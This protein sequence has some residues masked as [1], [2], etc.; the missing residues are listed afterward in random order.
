MKKLFFIAFLLCSMAGISQTFDV[1]DIINGDTL[2]TS[3]NHPDSL[4]KSASGVWTFY[5][6][7]STINYLPFNRV[8]SKPTTLAGYGIVDAATSSSLTGYV[9]TT[10]T[11]NG[12]ALSGNVTVTVSDLSLGN[13]TNTS[14]ANKP[15][16]TAQQTALDFKANIASPTFTGTVGGIT[17]SMVGLGNVTNESKATMFTNATFTGTFAVTAGS[18]ANAALA[19][20]AV[21]NLSGTN[22]GDQTTIT[23]NAGSATILFTGRT[24]GITGDATWTSPSFDGSQNVTASITVTKINGTSLSGLGTGILKN[25]TGTGVPS[26]A[27]AADFP[28]LNQSTSGNAATATILTTTRAIYGNNFDGSTALTQIIASTFGGTGNGFTK[29]TGPS[30]SE[31][32]FTLPNATATILTDNAVVTAAQGGTGINNST[33]TITISSNAAIFS[34]ASGKTLT[35]SNSITIAGTDASTLNVGTGGTL[36]TNA[37]NSTAYQPLAT[38]LTSVGALANASGYLNNNGSGVFSYVTPSGTG[39]MI[40]GN[41]QLVT[42]PKEFNPGTLYVIGSATGADINFDVGSALKTSATG[43]TLEHDAN[44]DLYYTKAAG[45][46]GRIDAEQYVVLSSANT[47]TSQT[48]AQPLFDGGGGP[49]N[50]RIT[51]AGSTTYY[52]DCIISLASMSATSG[53][54]QFLLAGTATLTSVSYFIE[55]FDATTLSSLSAYSGSYN[56][57]ASSA[58]SM[59]TAGA[60]TGMFAHIKGTIRTN[61]G[62]TLIPQIA[63]VTAAAAT[64]NTNSYFRIWVIGTNTVVNIGNWD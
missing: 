63:L 38:N 31:K 56:T 62:G 46:R 19:N 34:F 18:I 17:A 22:S 27:I 64:V 25:T 55:G 37:F 4:F 59:V 8:M 20:S 30:A 26:I 41:T 40:L 7:A 61:V 12:H 60:G 32:T 48:A 58:A 5:Y 47:L 9:A 11:V 24:I 35:V 33:R 29:F 13:V 6:K 2:W 3:R 53:N 21:A 16:S 23:G 54:G 15:V 10:V 45:E 1:R 28:T 14:D 36:G 51:L 52:F 49:A 42:G 43:G 57:T 39:D 44:M 50:G